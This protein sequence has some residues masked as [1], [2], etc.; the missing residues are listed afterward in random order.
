[1]RRADSMEKTLM[2]G[3]TEGKRRRGQER[4]RYLDSIIYSMDMNWSNSRTEE[5]QEAWHNAAVHGVAKSRHNLATGQQQQLFQ[6][7]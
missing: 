2:L 4:M 6:Q 5:R 7:L 3:K 1:M